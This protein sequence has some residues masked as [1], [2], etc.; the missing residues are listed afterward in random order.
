M[1]LMMN[2]A[3]KEQ[4]KRAWAFAAYKPGNRQRMKRLNQG[5]I[6][7]VSKEARV[8]GIKAGMQVVEARQLLPD[9]RILLYGGR[10]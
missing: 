8:L 7:S 5:V 1:Q 3:T 2:I 4:M 10:S 6:T 9:L